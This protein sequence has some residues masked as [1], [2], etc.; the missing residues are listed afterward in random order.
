LHDKV[1]SIQTE[2]MDLGEQ[3]EEI[4]VTHK[5]QM[6]GGNKSKKRLPT[7][8]HQSKKETKKGK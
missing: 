5:T 3:T 1:L 6:E 7:Q 4:K 8:D 2:N